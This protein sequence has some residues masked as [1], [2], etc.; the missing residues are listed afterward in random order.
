MKVTKTPEGGLVFHLKEINLPESELLTN[1]RLMTGIIFDKDTKEGY[2]SKKDIKTFKCEKE[3]Y[4][5][6]INKNQKSLF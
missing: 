3:R 5:S 2:V 1:L 6:V 4:E